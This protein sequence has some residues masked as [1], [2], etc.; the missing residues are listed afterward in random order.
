[1][2]P[3]DEE[4]LLAYERGFH[5]AG[6]PLFIADRS[7]ATDI[8]NRAAPL[9]WFVFLAEVFGAL[10][11]DWSV[12]ANVAAVIAA[13]VAILVGISALNRSRGRPAVAIPEDVGP[14]ELTAFVLVPA[15]LPLVFG[16]QW[17][18]AVVTAAGN[19]LLLGLIYAVVGLGLVS[20]VRWTLGRLIGQLRASLELFARAVPLLMIFSVVLFLTAEVWQVFT[21]VELASL[22]ILTGLFVLLGTSFLI[23]R[24]PREVRALEREAD[25]EAP[26]LDKREMLN[27][28]LV[29]FVSQALQV[30]AVSVAIGGFFV[31]LGVLAVDP[32]ITESWTGAPPN[33]LIEFDLFGH[34]AILS[35][36]LLRVAGAIAAFTGLYFTISM[37]TDDVY[38]R[39]FLDEL[40]VEM[41]ESFCE[42][43]EYLR[44]RAGTNA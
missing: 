38:R 13:L 26:P 21:T 7:A 18:S 23:A 32:G 4:R 6:L 27:V 42:R 20:I 34:D 37:L 35:E 28:G 2:G 19:V 31:A 12:W 22:A 10:N 8:F 39:E 15:I 29:M 1:M 3:G 17:L 33:A 30:L 16:G 44:L 40:T 5:H 43:A 11:L 41:R 24:L 14:V 25:A 36:E 9:L